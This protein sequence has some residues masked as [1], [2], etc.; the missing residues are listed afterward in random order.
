[1]KAAGQDELMYLL[2]GGDGELVAGDQ[3]GHLLHAQVEELL[4]PD[5]LCEVLLWE[6]TQRFRLVDTL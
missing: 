3:A 6:R 2:L 5:H 1:M 4:A